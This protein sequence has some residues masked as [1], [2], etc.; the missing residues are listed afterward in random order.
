MEKASIFRAA[1]IERLSTPDRLDQPLRITTPLGWLA[2]TALIAL[3]VAGC[4][5]SIVIAVPVKVTGQG[6]ILAP[7]GIR[8]VPFASSGRLAAILVHAGDHIAHGQVVARLDQPEL[9]WALDQARAQ[10]RDVADERARV[11]AFQ[12]EVGHAQADADDRLRRDLVQAIALTQQRIGFL[13]EREAIDAD[14]FA[15]NLTTRGKVMDTKV[16]MGAAEEDLA[17]E[18]R[19]L[20]DID[21]AATT[22]RIAGERELLDLDLKSAGAARQVELLAKRLTEGQTVVS[23]Y[24]GTVGEIKHNVG[25]LARQGAALLSLLPD[26][27]PAAPAGAAEE[28]AL[29]AVLYVPASDGKKIATGMTAEIEPSTVRREEYGFIFGHVRSVAELPSTQ[30][31]MMR[32]LANAELVTALSASGAPFE[33]EVELTRDPHTPSGFHWSSG[34]GPNTVVGPGTLAKGQVWV[35]R[36]RLIEFAIPALHR[37]FGDDG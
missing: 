8:D 36:Q 29:V 18:E 26:D 5:A 22:R 14:L 1:A 6:I 32:I 30:D 16:S 20:D 27:A 2:L 28:P 34:R 17:T 35:H 11:V 12:A 23:P 10:Q 9:Q 37:L 19:Q 7:V 3:V 13:N 24:D 4:I 31:G 25:E 33:I 15:K 21:H